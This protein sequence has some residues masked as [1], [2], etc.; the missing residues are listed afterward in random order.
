MTNK[1]SS[2]HRAR[3][4]GKL[5]VALLFIAYL[6]WGL[7][8]DFVAGMIGRANPWLLLVSTVVIIARNLLGACRW[9]ILLRAKGHAVSIWPLLRYYFIGGFFNFFL[10]TIVGGD[11]ARGY[12]LS[13]WGVG[14]S[15]AAGSILLERILGVTALVLVSAISIFMVS[16][17]SIG[18]GVSLFILAACVGW[19]IVLVLLC[20][21]GDRLIP[22]I[23]PGPLRGRLSLLSGVI[24]EIRSYGKVRGAVIRGFAVTVAFQAAGVWSTY[25]LSLAVGCSVSAGYFFIL[26]PLVWLI[27][28]IP[29]SINGLGLREGAFVT[30]FL[31]VGMT[32]ETAIAISILFLAQAML[33]GAIGGGLYL[34]SGGGRPAPEALAVS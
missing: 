34:V 9:S 29:I 30:L 20:G 1:N 2:H 24:A 21:A 28:M 22:K 8:F 27:A 16:G 18:A 12:Y 4:A 13:R 19:L 15:A 32:Q 23:V 14:K 6:T 7:D 3:V 17:S 11:V 31:A 10:P 26:L 33:Q 25:L 5:L